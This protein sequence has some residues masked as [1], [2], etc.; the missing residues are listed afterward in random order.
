MS[1]A[2]YTVIVRSACFDDSIENR[3]R[4][5]RCTVRDVMMLLETIILKNPELMME[6]YHY[7]E[8]DEE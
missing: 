4:L 2:L 8:D 7:D 6:I 3:I 1:P 5:P